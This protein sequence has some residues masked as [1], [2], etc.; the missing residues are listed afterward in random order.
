MRSST[1]KG[2]AS[3]VHG[4]NLV[5]TVRFPVALPVKRRRH[6]E[7]DAEQREQFPPELAH[8]YRIPVTHDRTGNP[9]EADNIVEED[10]DH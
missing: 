6:V 7:L 9:M 1:M 4:N 5:S 2:E 8:E 3:K 10:L